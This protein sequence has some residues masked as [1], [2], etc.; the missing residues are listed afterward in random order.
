MLGRKEQVGAADF[1]LPGGSEVRPGTERLHRFAEV[2]A[3]DTFC[4]SCA[5]RCLEQALRRQSGRSTFQAYVTLERTDD[6]GVISRGRRL[7]I[8]TSQAQCGGGQTMLRR[9]PSI[10]MVAA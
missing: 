1:L 10:W 3:V 2:S 7:D 8:L 6:A 4:T 9:L 5:G